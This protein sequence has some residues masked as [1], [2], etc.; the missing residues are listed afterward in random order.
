LALRQEVASKYS[1]K[2]KDKDIILP[3]INPEATSA[4][5]QY[6]IRVQNRDEIQAKLKEQGIPTA[7]HYPM[8]LHLQECFSYLGYKE[9][10]FRVAEKI[11]Q[12]IMSLPMNPYLS[13]DEIG[14]ISRNF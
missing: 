9:G 2:L 12:E 7:I 6:S 11:S 10:D 14:Y 1:E 3:F 13:D 8:P 4:F 5:A